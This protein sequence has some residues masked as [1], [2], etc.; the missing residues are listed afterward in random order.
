M[1]SDRSILERQIER[2]ELR[3]FTLEGFHRRRQRRERNRRVGTAVLA[4]VLATAAFGGLV[5]A[6][7]SGRGTTPAEHP[8]NSFVGTWELFA[9]N[10]LHTL[11]IRVAGD[12]TFALELSDEAAT[13]CDGLPATETG[14][15][16]LSSST[17]MTVASQVITCQDGT[18]LKDVPPATYTYDPETDTL[19]GATGEVWHRPGSDSGAVP[20]RAIWPQDTPEEVKQAQRRADAGDPGYTWQVDPELERNLNLDEGGPEIFT[21]FL[22]EELGWEEFRSATFLGNSRGWMELPILP[23]DVPNPENPEAF[24]GVLYIRCAPGQTN[25]LYPDDPYGS[26][27]APT[28]DGDRYETVRID[29]ARLASH[30]PS[31]IWVVTRWLPGPHA[32]QAMPPSDAEVTELLEPFLQARVDGEGAEE[33]LPSP[34]EADV[35]L[36]YATTSGAPYERFEYELVE[37]PVWPEGWM[38]FE[39]RLFA[40]GRETVVEQPFFLDRVGVDGRLELDYQ[41]AESFTSHPWT[42]ENG[43]AVPLPYEFLD[44]E[45]TFDAAPPWE[46]SWAGW[47]HTPTMTTLISSNARYEERLAAVADPLPVERGCQQG[48]APAD[49]EALARSIRS[50]PDLEATPPVAVSIGGTEA[51]RMDVVAAPGA[52]V[53]ET[54]PAPQVLTPNDHDWPGVGLEPGH[55]MRLYLLDLPEGLSARILAIAIVAPEPRLERVVEAAAPIVDSFEFHT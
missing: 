30:G 16:T 43:E 45:V 31:G 17:E 28:I 21:R 5:R 3:P 50:D 19:T 14:V 13:V 44:G 22:R 12:G 7:T 42:T 11:E 39:V 33:Y 20:D 55:R 47:D 48:P 26:G 49:A 24:T 53:C 8:P 41:S 52:S 18:V 23:Y 37:G 35:P 54:V 2:V 34:E 40:E 27:C 46:P 38:G 36:L 6:F 1:T 32:V 29:V 15:G 10:S 25:P 9:H 4:L 51:L